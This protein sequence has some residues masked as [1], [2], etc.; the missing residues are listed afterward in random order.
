[1]AAGG[2]PM[3]VETLTMEDMM[4]ELDWW[5]EEVASWQVE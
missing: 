5:G 1:M 4:N 3:H 2:A